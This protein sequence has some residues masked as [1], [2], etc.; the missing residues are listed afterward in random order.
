MFPRP[1][2]PV[3]YVTAAALL[4]ATAVGVLVE[5]WYA[6][7]QQAAERVRVRE[8]ITPYADVVAA[9]LSRRVAQIT[10]LRAFVETAGSVAQL[11]R[12]FG[13]FSDGLLGGAPGLRAVEVVRTGRISMVSPLR[14]NEAA[15]TI[16]FRRHPLEALRRGYERALTR[17]A[18]TMVGPVGLAQGGRGLIL[19]LRAAPAYDP[20]IELV[21]LV[22]DFPVFVQALGLGTP[23]EDL[24]LQ[25]QSR[26]GEVMAASHGVLPHDPVRVAIAGFDADWELI[27]APHDGWAGAAAPALHPIRLAIVLI[28]LLITLVTYQ[29]AGRDLRLTKLVDVRTAS[30]QQLAEAQQATIERQ[31]A[32]ERALASSEERLRL[33]LT[34]SRTATFE[35]DVATGDMR[36]SEGVGPVVGRPAGTQPDSFDEALTYVDPAYR[37][38]VAAAFGSGRDASSRGALEVPAVRED[39]GVTWLAL[40]WASKPD[41][42]GVVR[43]VVGTMTD[44]SERKRL[45]EQFLHA[46]KMQ[47]MGALAGGVAH[48]FNNL[49][50]VIFGA[51]HMARAAAE[52]PEV[53]PEIRADLDEVLAAAH[54]ASVLTGQLLA[55]SRRQIVQPR[56]LDLRALVSGMEKMLRRLVGEHIQVDAALADEPL[57]VFADQGQ[58]TQVVMNLAIN[59]R[60]AMPDG[61]TLRV[62][63]RSGGRPTGTPLP[64]ESLSADRFAILSVSD[65]GTGIDPTI[66]PQI[67]EPFFTTKPVG[68]G[69]GLGL[70]TVYGIVTSLGGAVRVDSEVGRGSSLEVYI[71]LDD[72]AP[73]EL[74]A[75]AGPDAAAEREGRTVLLA[76]D[77]PGVRKLAERIL[78]EAGYRL[79][80][81]EDGAAALEV[82]RA[83]RGEI[84]LLVSDVV[85]PRLGGIEL[86]AA[87]LAERPGL[88]VLMMSGYPQRQAAESAVVLADVPFLPKPFLA[89]DLRAAAARALNAT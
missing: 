52:A 79:L 45:E 48:D 13:P 74:S 5:R 53:A 37:A 84:H 65:T 18:V 23:P 24:T 66:V 85:M 8:L 63:L 68:Q 51:G 73:Q 12:G 83:Y 27:G 2:R 35:I 88:R 56:R 77:E 50:T 86:A 58:L 38:R 81:A 40:S 26:S 22:I 71:P 41:E 61:G 54:R 69:T 70:A 42:D 75:G 25:L 7:V 16:E 31:R 87:L 17:D 30:L 67:F 76:E 57:T 1:A 33:A 10:A 29:L 59:A 15:L 47:A 11:E 78:R 32:T 64:D 89:S 43:R 21:E 34:A 49:L 55:F 4:I 80:V 9:A 14:G 3:V 46:Q 20:R 36:W 62:T 6:G 44:I 28:V 19:F 39:G 60:D 72:D 82:A